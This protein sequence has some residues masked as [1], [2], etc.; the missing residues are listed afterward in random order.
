MTK[1]GFP[2]KCDECGRKTPPEEIEPEFM[3]A[4]K[5]GMWICPDCLGVKMTPD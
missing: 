1:D 2:E 3:Y 4:F 5:N